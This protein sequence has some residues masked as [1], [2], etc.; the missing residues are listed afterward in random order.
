[1]R[2][3]RR[4]AFTLVE[5]LAVIAIIAILATLTYVY[6]ANMLQKG[7]DSKRIT[8]IS[9]IQNALLLYYRD[10]GRYPDSLDFGGTLVGST[11]S[12]TY[13]AIVPENPT[14]RNDGNCPDEEFGYSLSTNANGK[15]EYSLRFCLAENTASLSSGYHCSTPGGVGD[16]FVCGSQVYVS[17]L[18]NYTCNTGAPNFDTCVYDSVQVGDQCWLK[19]NINL[20]SMTNG[21]VVQGNDNQLEKYC[22]DNNLSNCTA[23]GGLYLWSEAMKYST[24]EGTQGICPN[25]WHIPT[26][27]EQ[28]ELENYLKDNGQTCNNTR[29]FSWDCDTAGAK[30]VYGG[31]SDFDLLYSGQNVMPGSFIQLGS[32]GYFWT[33]LLGGGGSWVRGVYSAY[34]TVFRGGVVLDAQAFSVRCINDSAIISY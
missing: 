16:C 34:S 32:Y 13:M 25:G 6:F 33:S 9:Q 11:S 1:M 7:R 12:T 3:Y 14:P 15:T 30:L 19:Q 17:S 18:G 28:Y 23:Y 5:L 31:S 29:N 8:E 2:K 10:E 20:G 4:S 24:E 22:Y 27:I 26:D 21:A